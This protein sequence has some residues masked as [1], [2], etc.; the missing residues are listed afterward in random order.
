[1]YCKAAA[2][3]VL[4]IS[5]ATVG[6]AYAQGQGYGNDRGY[7]T[8]RGYGNDR[9]YRE[10]NHRGAYDNNRRG[11]DGRQQDYRRGRADYA[12]GRNEWRRGGR[13]PAEY[14]GRQYYVSDWRAHRLSAPPHGYRWVQ[15]G[16]DYVLAAITTGIIAQILLNHH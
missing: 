7:R 10:N 11:Y 8:D 3:A 2:A 9:G 5:L 12:Y 6:S 14:R 13:L 4:A 1:M 15:H 16:N